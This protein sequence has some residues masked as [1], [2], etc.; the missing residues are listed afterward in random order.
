[1]SLIF[2]PFGPMYE[3]STRPG[4]RAPFVPPADVV[5]DQEGITLVMDVPGLKADDLEIELDGHRLTVRGERKPPYGE[6]DDAP[7]PARTER[8]YGAFERTLRLAEEFDADAI[9]GSIARGVLTLR[10]PLSNA[11]VAN[12]VDIREQQREPEATSLAP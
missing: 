6:G 7:A 12:R 1:M 10:I 3:V 8:P 2:E 11:H 9:E 4:P 5:A